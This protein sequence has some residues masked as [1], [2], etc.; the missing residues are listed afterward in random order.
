[1]DG[2]GEIW[3]DDIECNGTED[4]LIECLNGGL[5]MHNCN[6]SQDAGV[7]CAGT[8]CTTGDIRLQG[9]TFFEGRVEICNNNAWGTVC[10]DMWDTL[11]AQV[12]CRQLGFINTSMLIM[13]LG[14]TLL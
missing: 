1:M 5:G 11:E 3:L 7:V 8:T 14:Y 6:H 9:G 12:A 10:S 2:T 4:R 13:I